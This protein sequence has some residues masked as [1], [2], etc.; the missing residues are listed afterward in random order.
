MHN[1]FGIRIGV[2]ISFL[3]KRRAGSG[4]LR[5][6]FADDVHR[7]AATGAGG[8]F[9]LDHDLHPRQMVGH[10]STSFRRNTR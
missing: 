1:V 7:T 9:R 3:V 10:G 5:A 4:T 6:V 2:A 8:I